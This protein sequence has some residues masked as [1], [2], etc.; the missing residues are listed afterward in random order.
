MCERLERQKG[1]IYGVLSLRVAGGVG[2]GKGF[3]CVPE[4]GGKE[5]VGEVRETFKV[6]I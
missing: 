2:D 6:W 1:G 5:A 4:M 3:G